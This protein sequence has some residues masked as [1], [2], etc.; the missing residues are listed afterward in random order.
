MGVPGKPGTPNYRYLFLTSWS[1]AAA[2]NFVPVFPVQPFLHFVKCLR[3]VF[4]IADGVNSFCK[5]TNTRYQLILLTGNSRDRLWISVN[6]GGSFVS[7]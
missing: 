3:V 5:R 6:Q 7:V 4:G 1:A 2:F